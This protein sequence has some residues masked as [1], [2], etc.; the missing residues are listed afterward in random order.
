MKLNLRALSVGVLFFAAD[1]AM[2]QRT[3]PVKTKEAKDIEEVVLV[4]YGVQ[5][6]SEVTGAITQV[7]GSDI[8]N[9]NTPSFESQ[10]AG[11][12]AGVQI[13]QNSGIIGASPVVNIRGINSISSGTQPLYV[14][15]GMPI[16]SGDS[17][18][19]YALTNS[20]GDINPN[21]I[22]SM[23][24]LK[25]GAATAIYGSR[26]ANGV[27]LITTKKGKQGRF[28][29]QYNNLTTYAQAAKYFDLLSTPE[30]LEISAEKNP[31]WAAGNEFNTD[32]QKVVLRSAAQTDNNLSISGGMGNGRYL[33][34]LGHTWQEG[35]AKSNAMQRWTAKFSADQ[36]LFDNSLT[37]GTDFSLAKTT[38]EGL[39]NDANAT[40]GIMYN[41]LRQ[42]P[43]TP[44][45]DPTNPTGYNIRTESTRS[46]VGP[47]K[48]KAAIANYIPNI[49]MVLDTNR[50]S[51]AITRIIG[52]V[53]ANL[54][55]TDWMTYRFQVGV[56]NAS[57]I[58]STFNNRTHGDGFGR[59]GSIYASSQDMLRWNLQNILTMKKSWGDHN[60]NLTLVNEYQKESNNLFWGGGYGLSDNFFGANVIS[61][62]YETQNSG[63]GKTER[64]LLSYAG[65]LNYNFNNR[66]FIQGSL[67][68]DGL[69]MLSKS[70]RYGLFPG[71][72]IGWTVLNES[73]MSGLKSYVSDLKLRASYAKV[74]NTN[75]GS[76]P[77]MGLYSNARYGDATGL[78]YQQTGNPDLKWETS[79]KIGAGLDLGFFRN[80]LKFTID[81]YQN[82]IDNMILD[83]PYPVSAGLPKEGEISENIGRVMNKGFEFSVDANII[84]T[85]NFSWQANMNITTTHNEVLNLVGDD[86]YLSVGSYRRHMVGQPL[87]LIWGYKYAGVNMANGNPMYYKADGTI[88]QRVIETGRHFVYD[89]KNPKDT[90]TQTTV[91]TTLGVDDMQN[92]GQTIPK[93]FGGISNNFKIGKFDIGGLVRFSYGNKILNITK[94]EGLSMEFV[95]NFRDILG[96]WQSPENPGDGITPRI[97]EGRNPQINDER[98]ASSRFVEDGSFIKIDNISLGYTFDRDLIKAAKMNTLRVFVQA[99][100]YFIFTKYTGADPEL[101]VGGIDWNA[102]PRQKSISI[103]LN[104]TF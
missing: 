99:Q 10:L 59:G 64:G 16:Y 24:V 54:D 29:V 63:G 92:L 83:R 88:V 84:K 41:A 73:F 15:D 98:V 80:R 18:G 87:N 65:R 42:L 46:Y 67:R 49:A 74:G 39:T 21:D 5:K 102:M 75:I 36:K 47:W 69:S 32:W 91:A 8:A 66:Y 11:R 19:G 68:Y 31:Q 94:Q 12:S 82:D 2:A 56:D 14:V 33:A 4:G 1:A 51:S 37:I 50:R 38:Y 40:S 81:Y 78:G 100:N 79:E 71:G 23:E 43:N 104:A 30:F 97:V 7:K 76:Y 55:L 6:K 28:T 48:N 17:E 26:G 95:N 61:G 70:H 62:S 53:Y 35:I 25:D 89:P 85:E 20:L 90:G 27:I 34:S 93:F 77:Y 57:T 13:I 44:V 72:S 45:Y 22:E 86:P 101:T 52:N 103:G 96:R 60:F 9:L 3:Q 58:G